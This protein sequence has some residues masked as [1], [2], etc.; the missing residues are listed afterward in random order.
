MVNR[1]GSHLDSVVE[2]DGRPPGLT[3]MVAELL[4]KG[5]GGLSASQIADRFGILGTSFSAWTGPDYS[6]FKTSGLSMHQ[7][8]ILKTFLLSLQDLTLKRMS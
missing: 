7:D 6:V 2:S 5:A 1:S 4:D 8:K 3:N